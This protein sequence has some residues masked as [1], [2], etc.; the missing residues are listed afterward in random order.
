MRGSRILTTVGDLIAAD[1]GSI[2]TGPFGTL[3][4]A[5]EYTSEGVPLISVGEIGYGTFRVHD[6]TPRVPVE[7]TSRLEE[8]VLAE[9]DIVFGRKGAVDR[10]ARISTIQTGWF[11]GS[12]GIRLRLPP[13]VDSR[14]IAFQLQSLESRNWIKQHATGT[15]MASLNQGV[16]GRIPVWLPPLPD[17]RAIAHVLGTLDDKIELNRRRNQT[18]EAMARA[19]FK[20]WFV[21]FGPVR[22]KMEGHEPY[23]P[24]ELWQLFPDCLD[25][26]GKPQG[27][28]IQPLSELLTII[29]G[30]TPKTSVEEYWNGDIPWFSVV[31]TPSASDVFVVATAK[32][33][34]A[35]GL[36]GSSA[37]LIPKGTTIISAR[38]TVGNLAIAGQ[39]M[40]FN[41]SCYGLRGAG[42]AGDYFVYLTAQ[43]MV[44]Q[45]KSM[46]HGSVFSTITR[47]T[48]E[49]IR[50]P[51]PP[52]GILT[53][54]ER[55][56]AEWFDAILSNV[57]ESRVLSKLRDTLLPK[58]ISGEIRIRDAEKLV[59]VV[60]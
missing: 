48:F 51:V 7:V 46:A 3:L 4:K 31:D 19:L 38:G 60:A 18:L 26:D 30:G 16:V 57:E 39:E 2:K 5:H 8:Y 1:G 43:H 58:L 56:V 24:G 52:P 59:E 32:T 12:D 36:A 9:G 50:R 34:T 44:D 45:L 22:A 53:I 41:Q 47:Q 11:L 35:Q 25:D 6:K 49:A 14:F 15:T 21:D 40:T 27:W 42:G 23:L 20:D 10:S 29:G 33:I 55:L 28:E 37:R 54:F 17:Q 13:T